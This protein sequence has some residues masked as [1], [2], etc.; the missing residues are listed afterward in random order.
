MMV[1]LEGFLHLLFISKAEKTF[2][3]ADAFQHSSRPFP[4]DQ[5]PVCLSSLVWENGK[6]KQDWHTG[7]NDALNSSQEELWT[8]NVSVV[9]L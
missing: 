5:S 1:A 7:G 4:V 6:D 2:Q 9:T 3:S 8:G